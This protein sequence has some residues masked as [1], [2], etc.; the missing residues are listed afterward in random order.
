MW[1]N[2][3]WGKVSEDEY[4][5]CE[6]CNKARFVPKQCEHVWEEVR[7][8]TETVYTGMGREQNMIYLSKCNKCGV[9]NKNTF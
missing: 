3:K 4:Q 7:N 2:H 9:M 8:Y 1:C 5:Y 6:K